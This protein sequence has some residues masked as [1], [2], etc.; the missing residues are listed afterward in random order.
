M[1][2]AL[3][4]RYLTLLCRVIL[5]AVFIFA[6]LGKIGDPQEFSDA[7]VAFRI[8]PI[9]SV[10]VFAIVLPWVELLVGLSLASGTQLR[11][12]AFLSV[13][14][15]LMFIIAAGSAMARGLDIKCGCFT[16]SKSHAS[17]GWSL[18]A[19][20]I[21]LILI[22]IQI[23]YGTVSKRIGNYREIVLVNEN[24]ELVSL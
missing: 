3:M 17:V 14:L 15:N 20:D 11:Q 1:K 19:R 8:L 18:I 13:L 9:T 22:A 5:A 10:N 7:I 4:N 2:N 21:V 6:A 24:K 16:L 23:L 12:S